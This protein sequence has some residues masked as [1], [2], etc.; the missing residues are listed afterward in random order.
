MHQLFKFYFV[1][2]YLNCK[3]KYI[4]FIMKN[5]TNFVFGFY[6]KYN[7]LLNNSNLEKNNF[8][9]YP[10]FYFQSFFFYKFR[11]FWSVISPNGYS[12]LTST[13]EYHA[14]FSP[15]LLFYS[16]LKQSLLPFSNLILKYNP[17]TFILWFWLYIIQNG[18][19]MEKTKACIALRRIIDTY[20]AE[21]FH[22]P[23]KEIIFELHNAKSG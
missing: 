18:I 2:N 7:N 21:P 22:I 11:F 17:Q 20:C 23:T 12:Y 15:S 10:N 6:I 4:S 19:P 1:Y 14:L 16:S 3:K 13:K 9:H 8:I 5:I